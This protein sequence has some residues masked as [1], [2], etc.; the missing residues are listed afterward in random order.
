[1][2]LRNVMLQDESGVVLPPQKI[3]S[4]TEGEFLLDTAGN[5]WLLCLDVTGCYDVDFALT[6]D[7]K[8]L[9]EKHIKFLFQ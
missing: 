8:L 3:D 7:L 6:E 5:L 1:M 4:Q 9:G 2:F